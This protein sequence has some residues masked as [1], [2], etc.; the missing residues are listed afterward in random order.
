MRTPLIA[1]LVLTACG[2]SEPEMTF[3]TSIKWA[4]Q[5]PCTQGEAALGA[6]MQAVLDIGGHEPCNLDIN[7]TTLEATGECERITIG[8]VRPLGLGYVYPD[9]DDLIP[10]AYVIG[11]V[12]LGKDTLDNRSNVEVP[13][14]ADGVTSEQ[15]DT[16]EGIAA[17]PEEDDCAGLVDENERRLCIAKAWAE[18][19]L[20]E[21]LTNFDI[22]TDT[23]SNLVEACNNT[24]IVP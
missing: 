5:V 19:R 23:E 22:D 4:P 18:D 15:V 16:N 21:R 1:L 11:W 9:G 2:S 17:L 3:A 6:N 10:L 13:L 14:A 20:S 12:D 8:I 7:P 24:L